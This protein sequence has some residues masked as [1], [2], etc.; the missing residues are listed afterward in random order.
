MKKETATAGKTLRRLFIF[1]LIALLLAGITP[2]CAAKTEAE[3]EELEPFKGTVSIKLSAEGFGATGLALEYLNFKL[4]VD[5]EEKAADLNV[6]LFGKG[7]DLVFAWDND[8]LRFSV[9]TAGKEVYSLSKD[10]TAKIGLALKTMLKKQET[11]AQTGSDTE[12]KLR[13]LAMSYVTPQTAS[14]TEGEYSYLLLGGTERGNILTVRLS[15]E[16]WRSFWT[17]IVALLGKNQQLLS[18]VTGKYNDLPDELRDSLS[19][20]KADAETLAKATHDWSLTMFTKDDRLCSLYL[21][22]EQNGLIYEAKGRAAQGGRTD[23]FGIRK[24]GQSGMLLLN[25]LNGTDEAYSGAL[26]I[27]NVI[28]LEYSARETA[29]G[30][31]RL[32]FVL[33]FEKKS[34]SLD[35][36]YA[37]GEVNIRKPGS[38]DSEIDDAKDLGTVFEKALGGLIGF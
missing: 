6:S 12:N 23:C 17:K 9:P 38:A 21:G 33:S 32:N 13:Y 4:G 3:E 36:I 28:T 30:G 37:P 2:V 27:G 26:K 1:L 7:I 31:A 25:T 8:T 15:E 11:D 20:G 5:T 16:Q 19:S 35:A 14:E 24:E 10:I 34:L 22:N 29:N 18:S